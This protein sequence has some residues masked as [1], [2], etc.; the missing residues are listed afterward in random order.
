MRGKATA[1][2][3]WLIAPLLLLGMEGRCRAQ[4]PGDAT[5][6]VSTSQFDIFNNCNQKITVA[7]CDVTNDGG[8]TC[9]KG[10]TGLVDLG[11]G[12]NF[13]LFPMRSSTTI[14]LRTTYAA[15][16]SESYLLQFDTGKQAKP[17][18][19]CYRNGKP[20]SNS[21]MQA[22]RSFDGHEN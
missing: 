15:C 18:H 16:F 11:P 8:E 21:I 22:S 2:I 17:K 5:H 12:Q 6:C 19:T 7:W 1:P 9:L 13:P 14:I 4:N 3:I 20:L 10:L